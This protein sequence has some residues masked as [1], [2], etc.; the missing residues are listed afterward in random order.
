MLQEHV[1]GG[2]GGDWFFHGYCDAGSVSRAAFTGVKDRSYPAHAGLTSL[3]RAVRNDD[4][5]EDM[6]ALLARLSYKA[7]PTW[8][9]AATPGPGST[10]CSTSTRGSARSSGCSVT[11]RGWMWCS[12]PTWT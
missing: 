7:S 6:R 3:G 5:R 4:L 2:P 12:P 10:S 1:P 8:T 11:G 9:C